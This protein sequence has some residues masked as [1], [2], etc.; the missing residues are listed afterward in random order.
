MRVET[1]LLRDLFEVLVAERLLDLVC[2]HRQ[3]RP[4]ADP[5]LDDVAE[6]AAL[7][8][9]HQGREPGDFRSAGLGAC[10]GLAT[11]EHAEQRGREIRR[12]ARRAAFETV[13]DAH[14]SLRSCAACHAARPS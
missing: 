7:E 13:E 4:G 3:V 6:A 5:R 14:G 12:R 9:L 10:A 11:A 8:L 1:V 2:A